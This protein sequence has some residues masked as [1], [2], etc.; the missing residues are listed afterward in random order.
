MRLHTIRQL[1]EGFP[2]ISF[3]VALYGDDIVLYSPTPDPDC[4][5]YAFQVFL[6]GPTAYLERVFPRPTPDEEQ[7]R[8]IEQQMVFLSREGYIAQ[9]AADADL[10]MAEGNSQRVRGIAVRERWAPGSDST[11]IVQA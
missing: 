8:T 1:S 4:V 3:Q 7:L 2:E 6:V 11:A 5:E 9:R 10:A